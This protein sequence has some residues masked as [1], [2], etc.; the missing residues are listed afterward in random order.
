MFRNGRWPGR[1][2]RKA[3]PLSHGSEMEL[4]VRTR[5]KGLGAKLLQVC[6]ANAL[7]ISSEEAP[8]CPGRGFLEPNGLPI[9]KPQ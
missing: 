9:K 4:S 8:V 1:Q 7:T 2:V 6:R 3:E 5:I